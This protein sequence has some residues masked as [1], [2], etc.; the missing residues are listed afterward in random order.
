[1]K[2]ELR[3]DATDGTDLHTSQ[4]MQGFTRHFTQNVKSTMFSEA[5][6]V[7]LTFCTGIQGEWTA[8]MGHTLQYVCNLSS[9]IDHL[10]THRCNHLP[11]LPLLRFESDGQYDITVPDTCPAAA[12]WRYVFHVQHCRGTRFILERRMDNRAAK[13]PVRC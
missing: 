11:R 8:C 4:H 9:D 3:S 10:S 1:M 7:I 6:L 2:T 5:Q 12:K 13:S